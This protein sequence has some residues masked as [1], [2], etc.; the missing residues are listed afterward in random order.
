MRK[1]STVLALGTALMA[2]LCCSPRNVEPQHVPGE[3]SHTLAVINEDYSELLVLEELSFD[4]PDLDDKNIT[5][6]SRYVEER[7]GQITENIDISN[8]IL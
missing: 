5:I 2:A 6:D 8:Y 4:A 3:Y 1:I 7:L